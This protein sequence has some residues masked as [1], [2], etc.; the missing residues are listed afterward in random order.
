MGK[1]HRVADDSAKILAEMDEMRNAH[2]KD[3]SSSGDADLVSGMR[4][5]SV[6]DE[7]QVLASLE[8]PA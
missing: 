3:T 1:S 6:V 5:L 2:K 7:T 8:A 4:A